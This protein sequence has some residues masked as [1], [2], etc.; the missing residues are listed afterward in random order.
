MGNISLFDHLKQ[1]TNGKG[2][3]LGDEGY[4]QYMINKYIS[5]NEYYIE[6][7]HYVSKLSLT[8]KQHFDVYKKFIPQRNVFLKY[9]GKKSSNEEKELQKIIAKYFECSTKEA[10]DYIKILDKDSVVEILEKFGKD[11]KEITKLLK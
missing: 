1:I 5:M 6:L 9:V 7:A 2:E 4:N 10:K 11:K 3:Y 8:N